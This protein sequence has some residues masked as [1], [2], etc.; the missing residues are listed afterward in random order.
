M[1]FI[2][3]EIVRLKFLKIYTFSWNHSHL[4]QW[5]MIYI[6]RYIRVWF[7]PYLLRSFR[8]LY[9]SFAG[10]WLAL[11]HNIDDCADNNCNSRK[12][13]LHQWYLMSIRLILLS[14]KYITIWKCLPMLCYSYNS[15]IK[16]ILHFWWCTK[17][18]CISILY[19][20]GKLETNKILVY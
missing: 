15:V 9:I 6:L 8:F 19:W 4:L 13:L 1:H 16:T 10:I 7:H 3:L 18:F 12:T 17:I 11:L 2:L 20:L 14:K 5:F